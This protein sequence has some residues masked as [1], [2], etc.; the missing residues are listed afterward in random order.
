MEEEDKK[1]CINNNHKLLFPAESALFTHW[2]NKT[3]RNVTISSFKNM[4]P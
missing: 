4:F 1:Q 2:F 3:E